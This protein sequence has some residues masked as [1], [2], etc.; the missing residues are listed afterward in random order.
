[1]EFEVSENLPVGE[2]LGMIQASDPDGPVPLV[3]RLIEGTPEHFLLNG[4]GSLITLK[5][6][7]F[8]SDPNS[9]Q[10]GVL[11]TDDR[12][13]TTEEDI[14]VRVVNVVEDLDGDGFE[15][16]FDP[17]LDGDGLPNFEEEFYGT[18]PR[19]FDTDDDGLSD[20][21]EV[22]LGTFGL[23]ED[24][25]EDGFDGTKLALA[26]TRRW[27]IRTKTDLGTKRKCLPAVSLMMHDY[28]GKQ[29]VVERDPNE[30]GE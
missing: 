27:R 12:N 23:F 3:M 21:E 15:D 8:E 22:E 14:I 17:D 20:G 28:P 4:N 1:M 10:L 16:A 5:S 25:D 11:V 18:D 9:F 29:V 6:F 7:D 2:T 26:P 13:T 30:F 19:L 24:S